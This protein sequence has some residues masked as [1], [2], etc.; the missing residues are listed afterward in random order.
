M[1]KS[2]S[3]ELTEIVA[4]FQSLEDPRS[5]INRR[6]PLVSVL[7]IALMA[8]LSGADGP[9]AINRWYAHGELQARAETHVSAPASSSIETGPVR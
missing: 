5:S 4:H 7:V 2:R 1:P 3:I 9:T 6:H 8:V